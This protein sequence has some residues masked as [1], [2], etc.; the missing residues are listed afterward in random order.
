MRAH[1]QAEFRGHQ[2]DGEI[3]IYSP[4]AAAIDL[5]EIDPAGLHQLFEEDSIGAVFAGCDTYGMNGPGDRSMAQH[6]VRVRWFFD[7]P[8]AEFRKGFHGGDGLAH[9]PSLIGVHH[10]LVV[11]SDFVT[12]DCSAA[13]II[14]DI[15]ADL[16]FE[17][18]PA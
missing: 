3:L 8:W 18:C 4:K 16:H 10:K 2:D 6:I 5:H 7:P 17:I 1:R 11:R 14:L 12:H 9:I 15:A 13:N